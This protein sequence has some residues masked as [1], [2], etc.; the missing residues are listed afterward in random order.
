MTK[1]N[2]DNQCVMLNDKLSITHPYDGQVMFFEDVMLTECTIDVGSDNE[3]G[4]MLDNGKPLFL[5]KPNLTELTLKFTA[6]T[7]KSVFMS[8]VKD[9]LKY[10]L[11]KMFTRKERILI[12]L[13]I[14]L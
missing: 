7:G 4:Q 3:T 1:G 10:K 9:S 14:F 8:D 2:P 5:K 6:D 11:A 13:C 12:F